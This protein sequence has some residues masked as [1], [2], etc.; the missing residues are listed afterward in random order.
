MSQ[1][2]TIL[3]GALAAAALVMYRN[4]GKGGNQ[5]TPTVPKLNI[6]MPS[7][8]SDAMTSMRTLSTGS[9]RQGSS[10]TASTSG[11]MTAPGETTDIYTRSYRRRLF[12]GAD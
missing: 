4:R 7:N 12:A 8:V 10:G 9:Q 3:F 11:N 6:Q 1:A 5:Q 2:N